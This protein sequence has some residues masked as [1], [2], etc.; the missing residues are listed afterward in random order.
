M[1]A[2]AKP[3][4][5]TQCGSAPIEQTAQ[6]GLREYTECKQ[7]K[8]DLHMEYPMWWSKEQIIK[9]FQNCPEDT[10]WNIFICILVLISIVLLSVDAN[11]P[12]YEF[13]DVSYNVLYAI[14][15]LGIAYNLYVNRETTRL[16]KSTA[17]GLNNYN[18]KSSI[19]GTALKNCYIFLVLRVT[20]TFI[21]MHFEE[22]TGQYKKDVWEKAFGDSDQ[23]PLHQEDQN[24]SRFFSTLYLINKIFITIGPTTNPHTD[25]ERV[26]CLLVTITGCLTVIGAAVASLSLSIAIYL[27]PEEAFRAR[28]RLI[29]KDMKESN[30]SRSLS[31][32]VQTFYKMYWH[33][34][35]AVSSTQLLPAFPPWLPTIVYT[36]IYFKATQKSRVLSDLSYSFLCEL[37]KSMHTL[38]YIPGDVIIKRTTKKSSIIYIT[39]GDVEML[40][41][42]DD[43]T[44]MLRMTRGTVLGACAGGVPAGCGLAHVGIR[45]AT[46]CTAHVLH[47]SDLWRTVLRYGRDNRQGSTILASFYEHFER[48]K[49]HYFVKVPEEARY[50]SSIR[51]FKRNLMALKECRDADGNLLL[52]RTDVMLEIAGCYIMRNRADA[53]LT[54]E[55]DDIC[56]RSTFPCILQPRSVLLTVWNFFICCL[57]VVVCFTHP[58]F[59]AYKKDVPIEFRFYDYVVTCIYLLD[60]FVY[61]STGANIED[62]A[63]ITLAQTAS[64]QIRSHWFVLDVVATMPVFEFIHDGHFAGINK[65]LRLPKVFRILKSLEDEWVYYSNFLRFFS[66]FLLLVMACYFVATL[67]Q[68]FMC[69]CFRHCSITNYTHPPFWAH[70]P[71]DD[72]SIRHYLTFG[73]YWAVSMITVTTHKEPGA[74]SNWNNVVYAM[75]VLELCIVLHIFMD[76]V[77]SASIMVAN[78]MREDYDACIA[79]VMNFLTRNNVEP[80]LRQRF[81]TYLQLCWY[82]DKGYK[83][84]KKKSSIYFDLPPHV[85]Q[86]IVN[87]QRSKYILCIPF[88]KYLNKEDLKTV[89]TEANV[90]YTSPNEILLNTGDITNEM[91]VIKQGICEI[92]DPETKE[93]V[94][95]LRTRNHFGVLECLLRFPAFYTVRAVTH[96]QLFSISRKYLLGAIEIPQIKDA[97]DF[98]K[99]QPEYS[100]LQVRRQRFLS[101]QPSKPIPKVERF[102]LPRKHEHD[103]AFLQPFH[104]LGFLSVLRYMFPRFTI[105]PD[106]EYLMHAEW[107]RGCC[108]V[109]SALLIPGFPY[110]V[111]ESYTVYFLLILLDCSAYFDILQRMLVGY[112][113]ENGILVYHPASTADHYIRGA[114]LIDLFGCLPLERLET[115]LKELYHDKYR[116]AVSRQYLMLNRLV[117]LY[118]LPS[119]IQGLERYMRRDIVLVIKAA[120]LYLA[121][122]NV[123]TCFLVFYSVDVYTMVHEYAVLIVPRQ[124]KGGS[125]VELFKD[126]FRFNLT[127]STWDLHL[128]S[129]FWVV[130]ETTTTGYNA[131]NPSN[132]DIMSIMFT[133]MVVGAMITTYFSVR[134]ISIRS[135]V[136]KPLAAFHQHM[137]DMTAFMDRE[138]LTP[139]IQKDV[140]AYYAYNWDKM[141]GLDYRN[142]LKLCD[143]ITLRTDAILDIYGSTFAMCP[144]LGHCDLSLVRTIGRAVRSL[145]FLKRTLIVEKDDVIKDIYIVDS[146]TVELVDVDDEAFTP[147]T[148][149]KGSI[150]GDLDGRP[151]LRSPV[152]LV[153]LSKVH[154]LLINAKAFYTI[155]SDFPDVVL[156]LKSYRPN[157]EKYIIGSMGDEQSKIKKD[158]RVSSSISPLL[159]HSSFIKY[160]NLKNSYVQLY[161]IIISF[162]S[163]LLETYNAGFQDNS[164]W[165][166]AALY[167]LDLAF[168]LK[169]VLVYALPFLSHS[170]DDV[171]KVM[172]TNVQRYSK[173]ETKYDIL[174]CLPLEL[175]SFISNDDRG[176]L[177][178]CL[179]LNR[180]FRVVTL[181]KGMG[182]HHESLSINMTLMTIYS[183]SVWFSLFVHITSC[184]WYFIG[185]LEDRTQPKSSWIYK[186]DGGSWCRNSYIC[187]VYFVVTT[188]TQNGIGDIMPKN[189]SEV[190]FVIVLQIVSAM[191]YLVYVGEFSNIFQ[192][193]SFRSFEYFCKYLELQEFLKN[194]RVSKNLVALVNKYSSHL[195]RESRGVQIPH[196][197]NT[198][199]HGLR[200]RLMSATFLRHLQNNTVF[201]K[202]EPAF[203][204][205]LVGCLHLYTYNEGMF[206]VRHGEITDSMYIIH[207]GRVLESEEDDNQTKIF[208]I[209]DC[210]GVLQG[211][212]HNMPYVYSYRTISKSQILTLNLN[213]WEDLLKHFPI[214]RRTIFRRSS[215]DD[216]PPGRNKPRRSSKEKRR[217]TIVNPN[218]ETPDKIDKTTESVILTATEQTQSKPTLNQS[219][220]TQTNTEEPGIST[221]LHEKSSQSIMK[222]TLEDNDFVSDTIDVDK[223]IWPMD[224]RHSSDL[225]IKSDIT[226]KEVV[227]SNKVRNEDIEDGE[228]NTAA[229][230]AGSIVT[231]RSSK[232]SGADIGALS[233]SSIRDVDSLLQVEDEQITS[234]LIAKL[235]RPRQPSIQSPTREDATAEKEEMFVK[236]FKY[237]DDAGENITSFDMKTLDNYILERQDEEES[238]I[239]LKVDEIS[240]MMQQDELPSTSRINK[241][242][243]HVRYKED[244]DKRSSSEDSSQ[245]E[246]ELKLPDSKRRVGNISIDDNK[247]YKKKEDVRSEESKKNFENI[248]DKIKDD[249]KREKKITVNY[250]EDENRKDD[251]KMEKEYEYVAEEYRDNDNEGQDKRKDELKRDNREDVHEDAVKVEDERLADKNK[252]QEEHKIDKVE[253]EQIENEHTRDVDNKEDDNEKDKKRDEENNV[254]K[255]EIDESTS[256]DEESK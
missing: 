48:V 144:I 189:R 120:P 86:N 172:K 59:I 175:F 141:G 143:Q 200:L 2:A 207:T 242:T 66:Y 146:G 42:E 33:K 167:A 236:D 158:L 99:K 60:L 63:P 112:F 105:R 55:S 185:Y 73:L 71:P 64:Q 31:K 79:D 106:S 36:D 65:L 92:I 18:F 115:L 83:M 209:G 180:V 4:Q 233:S 239:P 152:S 17:R 85:Y 109:L 230:R 67:Q 160:L 84:T 121:L 192:H 113:N 231:L 97:I 27:Q 212:T 39:Y 218:D 38:H 26:L 123:M 124:D 176:L 20:W 94:N 8:N 223:H 44:A 147:V 35:R 181:Y 87:R 37:A 226:K 169:F 211:L 49:R 119:A 219:V 116:I 232:S 159:I 222:P 6:S 166:I 81:I 111:L 243:L 216:S 179:R 45:A 3:H 206:V 245:R 43:C 195:W 139:A 178:S 30:V 221:D 72:A 246:M 51:E 170:D 74:M 214:S 41:A 142:V 253:E 148:L 249:E 100:R 137:K 128:A 127:K 28:Y 215:S 118:R 117:Q 186:N 114:F 56:L 89:S 165:M 22:D 204:R 240:K 10:A 16:S 9:N 202:C 250:R 102:R 12:Y 157:N 50:K 171:K 110:L 101:Y 256:N 23:F 228:V 136:N 227:P 135:I 21:W 29:M 248:E 188:F 156:L 149:T 213:E 24:V 225:S 76:S 238:L 77:Y 145:H 103:Y 199:P 244:K 96:V 187:S 251:M 57:I 58:Y 237:S 190:L 197:L 198:A 132:F 93:V 104:K 168:Y 78:E 133:G 162:L 107:C 194:N 255:L 69:F 122:L 95:E 126:N 203:L 130:Y 173:S 129:Y 177:F 205:Q 61:L 25:T 98:S 54:D 163:L 140:R 15:V 217:V 82:T 174:S 80:M 75:L 90:F 88:M 164:T 68:G 34:Q 220:V 14:H 138:N 150:F 151:S 19:L 234:A 32:E 201:Q 210:F 11:V 229:S 13:L 91:Y 161:L 134:I 5:K 53:S 196:F 46:F 1:V 131:I 191:V 193:Q 182:L 153:S 7:R 108:A 247:Q 252:V 155:I 62:G 70:E 154:L 254:L 47:A 52:A 184:L 241:H 183:V 208:H 235:D 125:W 40:T 224:S